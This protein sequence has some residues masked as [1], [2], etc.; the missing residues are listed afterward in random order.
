MQRTAQLAAELAG[1]E[2]EAEAACATAIEV[3]AR[4]E[5][6]RGRLEGN[7]RA[8]EELGVGAAS[9]HEALRQADEACKQVGGRRAR[10]GD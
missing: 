7:A 9:V 3:E 2:A 6:A 1:A 10:R 4:L 8:R 5:E